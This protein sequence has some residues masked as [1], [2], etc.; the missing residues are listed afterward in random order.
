MKTQRLAKLNGI[1]RN[2]DMIVKSNI[3]KKN[4]FCSKD[5]TALMEEG[6]IERVRPGYYIWKKSNLEIDDI[7]LA[8]RIIAGSVV[9]LF[10][11]ADI[12]RLSTVIP[13]SANLAILAVGKLPIIPAHPP[14]VLYKMKRNLFE[15]GIVNIRYKGKE[16]RIY[17]KERIVCDFVRLRNRIGTDVAIEVL[18][19]YLNDSADIQKLTGYAKAMRINK[20]IQTYLE[21]ML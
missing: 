21:A 1:F 13:Q 8:N 5:M 4:G 11:A 19:N 3:L 6:Y 12:Y 14:I 9:C 17:D 18:R 16:I 7:V 10:S 15:I 2:N 20:V